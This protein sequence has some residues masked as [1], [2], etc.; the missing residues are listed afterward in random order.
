MRFQTDDIL[1]KAK[2][3]ETVKRLT[4]KGWARKG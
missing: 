2:T 3:M 1:E 4:A